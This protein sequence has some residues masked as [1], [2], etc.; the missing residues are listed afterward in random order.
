VNLKISE[1]VKRKTKNKFIAI[2][3]L[4]SLP[5]FAEPMESNMK[6]S[7]NVFA[8]ELAKN[9]VKEAVLRNNLVLDVLE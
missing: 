6:M 3:A 4:I 1:F 2:S 8:K 9:T 7:A 5:P